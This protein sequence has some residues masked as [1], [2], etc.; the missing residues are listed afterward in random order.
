MSRPARR[1]VVLVVLDGWGCAPPGPGNAI[2]Q[3]ATPVFDALLQRWPHTTLAASGRDVGL[4]D[5]QMGNS[6]VGHLN[7]GAGRVVPQD[8]VRL[9]DAVRD[10]SLA[11][12]E[13]LR[14]GLRRRSAESGRPLHLMGLV[15]DGGVHSHVDHLRA[16]ARLAVDA[17]RA[18]RPRARHHRRP[19]RLA[20]PGRRPA[21]R[22]RA[23]VG[24]HAGRHPHRRRPLLRDGP[25]RP[26][27]SHR[28]A[29]TPPSSTASAARRRARTTAVEASYAAGVTDEFVEPVGDRRATRGDTIGRGDELIFFNFR[30]DR[31]RQ[32][33]RALCRPQL[34]RL[35]PRHA[36]A[37]AAP[38]DDDRLLGRP[39][40]RRGLRRGPPGGRAGRRPGARRGDAA[41][42]RRDRE[43]PA[44]DLLLQRRARGRAR[45]RAPPAGAVAAR[46]RDV[47]PA[48][49]D[50]R[51]AARRRRGRG[52]A[53]RA[54][55]TSPSSTS[56]TRTWSATRASS[57][58]SIRAVETVD[59]QLGARAR[60][61]AGG[62]RR[63][64]RDGR[65]RQRREDA[66]GR[67]LART[68]RTPRTRCRSS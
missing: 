17:G 31:A 64:R 22:A 18:R 67:R 62:R 61:R 48:A 24:G 59:A 45:R 20:A 37:A 5:G 66:R 6:E 16:L 19:R 21:R 28:S 44:R 51:R 39:A 56:P 42:R 47:R 8:L 10:G 57:R 52:A 7:I 49:R 26:L 30:P 3:A 12:N 68:R 32:V 38:D 36:A 1:P 40:R 29:T 63:R 4:P 33:C 13:A 54:A 34:R 14:A 11:R 65:P 55:R 35:R 43:V 25:R 41:A 60:R 27:G 46:R 50:E 2:E 15:S 23:G 9:G 53:G 58:R